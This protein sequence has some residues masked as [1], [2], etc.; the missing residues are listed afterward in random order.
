MLMAQFKVDELTNFK[1]SFDVRIPV[2]TYDPWPD[3]RAERFLIR[4]DVRRPLSVDPMVWPR[5]TADRLVSDAPVWP[6]ALGEPEGP[7]NGDVVRIV[8]VEETG[9]AHD[10]SRDR[11][12]MSLGY[13]VVM[14]G[15]TS[16][17]MNCAMPDE[18]RSIFAR[19]FSG[20]LNEHHL[21]ESEEAAKRFA[22]SF[23]K[24]FSE[25][26]WIEVF[27]IARRL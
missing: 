18:Q 13:D 4:S 20:Y 6:F 17:L 21:F 27:L 2:H 15:W 1:S 11:R 24:R 5:S 26:S 10:V 22:N 3:E 8:D 9:L 23:E 14:S 7:R 19:E 12:F 25:D 16:C